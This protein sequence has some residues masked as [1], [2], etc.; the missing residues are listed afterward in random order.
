[1]ASTIKLFIR[2]NYM[3]RPKE[4]LVIDL[5]K[6][7]RYQRLLEGLPQTHGMKSGKVH[8]S[9]GADCGRHSTDDREELL[10]FLS[11]QG[12]LIIEDKDNFQV[13]E[14]KISYI[15]PNTNH[16]VKNTGTEPLIYIYCVSPVAGS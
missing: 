9:P 13:G 10:V 8:L 6:L 16:N 5:D 2:E 15:P 11:G 4:A 14:G 12:I 3:S 1:M 7:P